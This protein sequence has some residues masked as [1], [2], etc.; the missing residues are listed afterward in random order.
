MSLSTNNTL[1]S[2]SINKYFILAICLF[3]FTVNASLKAVTDEGDIVIL[4]SNGTWVYE[5]DKV[6]KTTDIS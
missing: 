2:L 6:E 4:N 3:S 1:K 5:N